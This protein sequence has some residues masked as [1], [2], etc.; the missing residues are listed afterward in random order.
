MINIKKQ[1]V[2]MFSNDDL[3]KVNKELIDPVNYRKSG[4]SLNHII[5]C[6]LEC[7][8]CVRHV[9]NS[10]NMREPH[11][12]MTDEE[13]V[14]TL[15]SHHFF[16]PNITPIQIFNR[17]TDPFLPNVKFHTFRTLSLLDEYGYNNHVLIITRYHV[18]KKDCYI[19]NSFKSIKISVLITYSG[20]NDKDIEPI[21]SSI[22]A[23]S[24]KT[25]Y[26]NS[27]NYR[28]IMSWRPIIPN[29]NDT[30]EHIMHAID[31]AQNAHAVAPTGLF[32]RDE[33]ARHFETLN[34]KKPYNNVARRKILPK[35]QEE[36]I[37]AALVSARNQN[38]R[39]AP[40][41]R[42]TSCAIAYSHNVSDYNGHFGISELCDICPPRQKE[43]C[44]HSWKVP[45]IEPVI[46]ASRR[47]GLFQV[48][49]IT[50]RAI[51]FK[52]V[53]EQK[54]Y[55]IQHSFGYQCHDSEKP[56]RLYMH[57]R[58]DIGWDNEIKGKYE[59]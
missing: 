56:H 13:A 24:L 48:P 28:V 43:I 51:V 15:V 6:P 20:I 1:T 59:P 16:Q 2:P 30:Y 53:D 7:A 17:A 54:R 47:I 46:L 23:I 33:M 37:I 41:F 44:S 32:F 31:L 25:L 52:D 57:G 26:N 9:F 45:E 19:L 39:V 4:L 38:H 58:A 3:A 8:Y 27:V 34:L 36:K 11:A 21:D 22:A 50:N 18:S 5:G 40:I 29:V 35:N 49:V 12:I 10:Y 55:Y 42:K 14:K